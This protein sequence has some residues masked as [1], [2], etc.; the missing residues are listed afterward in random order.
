[1]PTS[2]T[3][4]TSVTPNSCTPIMEEW[5]EDEESG[6]VDLV[7]WVKKHL[8]AGKPR[9]EILDQTAL[10]NGGGAIIP[11]NRVVVEKEMLKYLEIARWCVQQSPYRRPNML[12]VMSLFKEVNEDQELDSLSYSGAGLSFAYITSSILWYRYE[13]DSQELKE[14]PYAVKT[15][16]HTHTNTYVYEHILTWLSKGVQIPHCLHFSLSLSLSPSI[17]V[18]VAP[19]SNSVESSYW[20]VTPAASGRRNSTRSNDC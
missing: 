6:G 15:Q 1:M 8:K 20:R 14:E 12:E 10:F 4:G 9:L 13:K 5:G 3:S 2:T 16:T 7:G 19:P 17:S 18:S 11:P